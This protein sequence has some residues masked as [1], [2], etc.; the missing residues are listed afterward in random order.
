VSAVDGTVKKIDAVAKVV[1][2]ET[3]DGA[4]HSFHYASDLAVHGADGT[5]KGSKDTLQGIKEGSTVAVH[6]TAKGGKETAHEIDRLGKDGLKETTVTILHF[7]SAAKTT[8]VKTA[9]GTEETYRLSSHATVDTAH[10]VY[11]A[12]VKSAKVT[13]YYT[14]DAG[15]KTAHFI[16]AAL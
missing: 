4:K 16:K 8:A 11:K 10:D 6:Y 3:V 14:E 12:T 13:I 9:D 5:V 7:D 2:V 1:S 15:K